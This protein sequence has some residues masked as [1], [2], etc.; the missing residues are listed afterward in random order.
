VGWGVVEGCQSPLV[1]VLVVVIER[2]K[3]RVLGMKEDR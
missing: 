1:L 2:G 3:V